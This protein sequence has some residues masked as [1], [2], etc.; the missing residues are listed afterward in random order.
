[1]YE[2]ENATL[3]DVARPLSAARDAKVLLDSLE[4]L[5]K[6][7]GG[8]AKQ[9]VPVAFKRQL[10][11]ERAA[12]RG[13]LTRGYSEQAAPIR[14]LRAARRT[15][16]TSRLRANGWKELGVGLAKVYRSGRKAM[17]RARRE[18]S[19]ENLHEW[20]KQSKYLWHELQ[21]LEPMWP[22]PIG[23]LADQVHRLSDYLGDDHDLAVLRTKASA[24]A[25]QFPPPGGPGALLALIDRCQERLRARA[26]FAGRR[27]YD[28]RPAAFTKRFERY[29]KRWNAEAPAREN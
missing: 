4:R 19:P 13:L 5:A 23:A 12:S 3:R 21:L 24:H 18:P 6:L 10:G 27:I 2:R 8:P 15:L 7:Y 1:V 11:R 16:L 17:K 20:R 26:F 25:E 14:H 28:E 29:W 9:S 22:G